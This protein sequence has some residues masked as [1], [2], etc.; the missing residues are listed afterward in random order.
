MSSGELE[1]LVDNDAAVQN[2]ERFAKSRECAFSYEKETVYLRS[3]VK[4]AD[5]ISEDSTEQVEDVREHTPRSVK[6]VVAIASNTM[7]RETMC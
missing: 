1:V 5:D 6:R 2:I 7:G 4:S 3:D